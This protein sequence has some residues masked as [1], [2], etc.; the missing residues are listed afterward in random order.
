MSFDPVPFLRYSPINN[1]TYGT[2]KMAQLKVLAVH[3]HVGLHMVL[4][5]YVRANQVCCVS[6]VPEL[7][8]I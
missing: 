5:T 1:T 3:K 8:G 7:G 2:E 6:A 4:R